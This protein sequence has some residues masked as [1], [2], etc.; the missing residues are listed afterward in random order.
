M[1]RSCPSYLPFECAKPRAVLTKLAGRPESASKAT[2]EL[3]ILCAL[4]VAPTLVAQ[5][6]LADANA[7]ERQKHAPLARPRMRQGTRHSPTVGWAG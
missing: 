6:A 4:N 1:C 5:I 2:S 3:T 7:T